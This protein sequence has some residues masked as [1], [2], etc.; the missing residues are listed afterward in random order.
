LT[1]LEGMACGIPQ[2]LP[3]WSALG[4]LFSDCCNMISCPTTICTPSNINSIGGIADREEFVGTLQELYRN[5]MLIPTQSEKVIAKASEPQFRWSSVGQRY[6][7]TLEGVFAP[8]M[9]RA[10]G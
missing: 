6:V 3:N 5:P 2:I 4:E 1:T 9:V 7:E 8:T 10:N